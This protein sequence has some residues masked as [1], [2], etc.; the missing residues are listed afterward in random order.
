M[1]LSAPKGW[2]DAP[3]EVHYQDL[4]RWFYGL[5]LRIDANFC[6][7]QKNVSSDS[8]DPGLSKGWAY[9]VEEHRY[10]MFLQ[11]VSKQPQEKSTCQRPRTPVASQ[12]Q[13]PGPLTVHVT[14]LNNHALLA[15]FRKEKTCQWSKNL[16]E[17]MARYPNW[18]HVEHGDKIMTFLVLKFHL[19]AHIFACQITYSHNLVKG[20]GCTDGEALEC[21]WAN[22]NPVATSTHEMGPGSRCNTLDDH[23]GDFNWKKVTNLGISLLQKLKA[24][25]LEHDQHQWDFDEFNE[26]LI[27]ERL[28]EV[29]RWKQGVEEWEADMSATNPFSPTTA[30]VT[31][32][33]VRLTLSQEESE[34]LEH[35]INNFLHNEI[36]PAVH[37]SS[38]IGI[39]EEHASLSSGVKFRF[40]TCPLW[41][42]SELPEVPVPTHQSRR[43]HMKSDYSSLLSSRNTHQ[44][45][46]VTNNFAGLNGNCSRAQ[47]FDVLNDLRRHLL[48]HTHLYKFKNVNIRGQR[49]N[50]RAAAVIRKVERNVIEAGE[51]TL[52]E[53][54]WQTIFPILEP[55]HMHGMSE[56]EAGQ[57]EGNWTLS[58]IWKMQGISATREVLADALHIEWCKAR[59]HVNRWTEE[60]QLLL[61]EMRRV[62]EFLSWHATWWDEQGGRRTGLPDAESEGIKGYAKRQASLQR[63]LQIAFNNM[64]DV[65]PA[66]GTPVLYFHIYVYVNSNLVFLPDPTR[67]KFRLLEKDLVQ[68]QNP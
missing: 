60:V 55:A 25:I 67:N 14:I 68:I 53:D 59:T 9:F 11:D 40:C 24:A 63:N 49:A 28:E 64:L 42:P 41:P 38:G 58:W 20:M 18:M 4:Y 65:S 50:T 46:S 34:E 36:S 21:G 29:G 10:K 47:A 56:G 7:A 51:R 2:E 19:P 3:P 6:L 12:Q 54:G 66:V 30:N 62:R 15:T 35:G 57:S 33:S 37:I 48:L 26:T 22:I 44:M 8:I 43:R 17:H 1:G 32:A 13:E 45:L 39:E 31:Q 16:W 23:F 52:A 5:F 27:T 61:E